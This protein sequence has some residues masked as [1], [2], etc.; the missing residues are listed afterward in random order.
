MSKRIA[1]ILNVPYHCKVAGITELT[2][3]MLKGI[4]P[5]TYL[6]GDMFWPFLEHRYDKSDITIIE[7]A[8]E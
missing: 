4:T 6:L 5:K 1:L 2:T 3:Y 7:R 8:G